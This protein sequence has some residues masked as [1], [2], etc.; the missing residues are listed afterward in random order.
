MTKVHPPL[1]HPTS[2]NRVNGHFNI[3]TSTHFVHS[4]VYLRCT[5]LK[6]SPLRKQLSKAKLCLYLATIGKNRANAGI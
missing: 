1:P 2:L 3:L 6:S 4:R 5:L